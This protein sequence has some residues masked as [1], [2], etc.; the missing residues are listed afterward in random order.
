MAN[1]GWWQT[2]SLLTAE[3]EHG[4]RRVTWL[5]LFYDL[6]FV[7]IIAELSHYLAGHATPEGLFGF[8]LMFIPVWWLWVGGTFYNARFETQDV[9][10]RLTVFSQ[11]LAVGAMTLFVHHG[12][13]DTANAFILSYLVARSIIVLSWIRGGW[14]NPQFRPVSNRYVIG[15]VLSVITLLISLFVAPPLRFWLWAIGIFFDIITPLFTL[16]HQARLPRLSNSKLPERYGLFMI[17]VLGE[18]IV[19]T[20]SGTAE[21]EILE[22]I[23]LITAALGIGF[24]FCIWWVYFDFLARRA[25]RPNVWALFAWS[26]LHMPLVMSIAAL[27]AGSLILIAD[28]G[29]IFNGSV[30]WLFTGAIAVALFAMAC[31]E[32]TLH[33][34]EDEITDFRTSVGI[35]V[36]GGVV[37][38][39]LGAFGGGLERLPLLFSL[40]IPFL[41]Q[42]VYGVYVWYH[43]D[44]ALIAAEHYKG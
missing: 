11:M 6:M 1:S 37:A 5:E 23:T 36:L 24:A 26:Y 33:N 21:Q 38:L 3:D 35:K 31:I 41:I 15:F 42:M 4:E 16:P 29:A 43:R 18:Q 22:P 12:M 10:N 30:R 40:L 28:A 8:I 17:I 9:S 13:D 39:L 25:P 14:H 32:T 2:P 34:K 7:V 27:G 20:I 19:G 44:P